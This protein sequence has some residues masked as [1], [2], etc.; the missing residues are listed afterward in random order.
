MILNEGKLLKTRRKEETRICYQAYQIR[1]K[2]C[3]SYKQF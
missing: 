1:E 2:E 3:D